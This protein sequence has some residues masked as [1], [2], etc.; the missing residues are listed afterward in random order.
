MVI[1]ARQETA[2]TLLAWGFL[3][4]LMPENDLLPEAKRMAEKYAAQPPVAA[5]MVKRSVN[6]IASTGDAAVMH[7]D[8][9]QY[10]LAAGS[11]D[12]QE[13]V[14]AFFEKRPPT[15]KGD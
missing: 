1:L 12:F 5:Q 15:F 3:D 4:Q 13:G 10:L 2:Q 6:A 7:M 8:A 9:D 11:K 14:H